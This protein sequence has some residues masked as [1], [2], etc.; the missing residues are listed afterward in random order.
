MVLPAMRILLDMDTEKHFDRRDFMR[1]AAVAAAG[2]AAF[3]A[4]RVDG[5]DC[6]WQIDP[7]KCVQC[8]RCATN[9]VLSPSAVKCVHTFEICGYC[10]LCGGYLQSGAKQRDTGAENELCPTGALRRKFVEEPF[11]EYTIDEPLSI[12]CAKC[13]KGCNMFGNGSLHLQVLHDRCVN[14]NEC[15]IARECPADAF[16]RVPRRAPYLKK[17]GGPAAGKSSA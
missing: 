2:G 16:Q 5:E 12:G 15:S 1:V 17:T 11:Y 10:D 8:G 4:A 3:W 13:V 9:C 6:V 7:F 14:C